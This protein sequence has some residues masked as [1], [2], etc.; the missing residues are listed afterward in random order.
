MKKLKS[1]SERMKTFLVVILLTVSSLIFAQNSLFIPRDVLTAYNK[2]TR[3]FD[4]KPG[5][6]YWQNS[7]DYKI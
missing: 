7:A 4:G 2:G 5:E 1:Y 3:S 6:S